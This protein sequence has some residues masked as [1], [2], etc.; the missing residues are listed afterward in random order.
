MGLVAAADTAGC[1]RAVAAEVARL[2]RE[3]ETVR[4]RQTGVPRAVAPGDV[5]ILFRSRDSHREYEREL[6]QAGVPFYVYKG[7]GFFDADEVK[8]VMALIQCLA[9]PD[10][11]LHVAAFLRSRFV[12][13][14][15][16]ALKRLAPRLAEALGGAEEPAV[17]ADLADEDRAVLRLARTSF[18]RWR[19][20]ADRL[21]PAELVDQV[22]DESAY[23]YELRGRGHAQA[24]ENLKKLRGL[25]RRLQNRGYATLGRIAERVS[26]LMSGDESNAI[27]DAADAVNL[28][29]VHAAKG[30]EFPIVFVVNLSRGTGGRGDVVDVVTRHRRRRCGRRPRRRG[31]PGRRAGARGRGPRARRDEAAGLRGPDP[32]SR[33]PVSC[34]RRCRARAAFAPAPSS[35]GAV[36]PAS[37]GEALARAA[38]AAGDSVEWTAASG[39][40]HQ[41]QVVDAAGEMAAPVAARGD[42]VD[43]FAPVRLAGT[44]ASRRGVG[45]RWPAQPGR[46]AAAAE[47]WRRSP[48]GTTLAGRISEWHVQHDVPVSVFGSDGTILRTAAEMVVRRPEGAVTVV[49]FASGAGEGGRRAPAGRDRGWISCNGTRIHRRRRNISGRLMSFLSCECRKVF[50]RLSGAPGR[51][52]GAREELRSGVDVSELRQ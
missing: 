29:T 26:Q 9:E 25:V 28:M 8:D 34:R 17:F 22:L 48:P 10:T 36:L 45:S 30:L 1:A 21:P 35:L 24:R 19:A 32:G 12:R 39:T 23:A 14:S 6:E 15:D 52:R 33:S 49:T 47:R 4:D 27:V 51:V 31:R 41:L 50:T 7:L 44:D 46:Q 37:L 2:L 18:A 16:A 3:G 13:L 5:A 42:T 11:H 20:L 40:V 38:S 43:D